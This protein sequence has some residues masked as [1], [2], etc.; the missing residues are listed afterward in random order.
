MCIVYGGLPS[1]DIDNLRYTIFRKKISNANVTSSIKPEEL[2]PTKR[3]VKFHSRLTHLQ[4]LNKF[5]S[6][7][8]PYDLKHMTSIAKIK[9]VNYYHR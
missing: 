8:Q 5:T 6:F 4:R 9:L 7:R 3:S 1:D 2:P